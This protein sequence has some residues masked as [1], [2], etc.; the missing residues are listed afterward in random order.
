MGKTFSKSNSQNFHVECYEFGF[1]SEDESY[2]TE[3]T[4]QFEIGYGLGQLNLLRIFQIR[5][6]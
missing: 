6:K 3:G 5:N 2:G 1:A 4:A